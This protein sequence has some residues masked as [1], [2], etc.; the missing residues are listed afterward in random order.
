MR[1]TLR[2]LSLVVLLHEAK[3]LIRE[4]PP[5]PPPSH[6]G[7]GGCSSIF[8]CD[9]VSSLSLSLNLC[10]CSFGNPNSERMDCVRGRGRGRGFGGWFG[11]GRIWM[12]VK[13]TEG[14]PRETKRALS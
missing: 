11:F 9:L 4:A 14:N 1:T 8:D 13:K 7:T 6:V 2:A 10:V 12:S 3:S 5:P